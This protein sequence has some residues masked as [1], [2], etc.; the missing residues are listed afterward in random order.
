MV[1][2]AQVECANVNLLTI[3][4]V[5]LSF[6]LLHH[7]YHHNYLFIYYI[8]LNKD[9]EIFRKTFSEKEKVAYNLDQFSAY[10]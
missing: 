8:T 6:K 3:K 4:N 10:K 2:G 5:I 9:Y 1:N 7:N